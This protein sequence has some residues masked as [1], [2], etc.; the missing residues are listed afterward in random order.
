MEEFDIRASLAAHIRGTADWRRSR[1]QDDLRD[2]RNLRSA[3]ALDAFADFV[4][5]IQPDDPR[6]RALT[7]Y[8]SEGESFT[9]GQQVLYEIGRFRF[10]D[11]ETTFDAFLSQLAEFARDDYEE[12][13]HFGGKQV[14]GDDPWV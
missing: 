4:L 6:L 7:R 12:H 5:T 14:P 11:D 13:G 9:P 10:F 3:G 1:F 2:P 8:A